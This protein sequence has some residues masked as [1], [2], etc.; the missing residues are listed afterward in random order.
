MK[1]LSATAVLAGV[2]L[3][4][5][6]GDLGSTPSQQSVRLSSIPEAPEAYLAG[7]RL[8]IPADSLTAVVQQYCVNCHNDERLR[9]NL[10]LEDFEVERAVEWA[11]T[12]EKMIVKL[13]AGMMPLPGARRPSPDTLLALVETLESLIDEEAA[14]HPNPGQRTFQRMNRAEYSRAVEDLLD[15]KVD[16]GDYLPLDPKSANFDNIADVQMF[17]PTLMAAYLSAAG[18]ISRLA[19][20][21]PN[22]PVGSRTYTNPGYVSQWDR[23]EGAPRGTRGGIS[24]VHNFWAD[25]EYVFNLAFEHTT[26]G[27]FYGQ[28]GASEQIEVSIDGERVALLDVDKWMH[29]QDPNGVNMETEAVFVRAGPHRVTAA[30]V[31]NFEGVVEDLVSPHDWS[32]ADRQIGVS[33]YGVTALAHL[34]DLVINGPHNPTGVSETPSRRKIFTCRPTTPE[35]ARPCAEEII[36]RLGTQAFRRPA[37]SDELDNLMIFFAEGGEPGGFEAG[38]RTAIQAILASPDFVFRLET[39]PRDVEPGESY[40]IEDRDLASRLSFFLWARPPD[41]ELM[42]LAE[43]GELSDPEVL[44]RQVRRMLGDPRS[45]ALGARFA[46]QWLRLQDL[47]KVHPDRLLFPDFYQQLADDMLLET[48]TFFNSLVRDDRSVFDLFTADFTF[49][50]E[51][52][53]NH[54]GIPGVSG[55]EFRR[56]TYPDARRR[57][58]LGHGSVLTLTSHANR[59]SPVLRGKWVMEVLFGTPPPPPPPGVPDLEETDAVVEGRMLTTRERMEM[60]RTDPTCNSCHRFMDPIGLALDNFDV[61]GRWRIREN[62]MPLDTQGELYDGTPV[63]SPEDLREALMQRPIP[64]V[65]NFTENLMAY[66]LGRRVEYYDKPTIRAITAGAEVDDYRMSSFILGVVNSGAFQ[67]RRAETT[68]EAIP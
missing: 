32:L 6:T 58:V 33:G 52:L 65:R 22:A 47:E 51:R 2:V 25:G 63:T 12:A 40:R 66:A 27:G 43:R 4:G 1:I 37:T 34:K 15:L 44:E 39:R 67:M 62:G 26:T 50:N 7:P 42:S 10:T 68:A 21:D 8:D 64:L 61:T 35:E 45:E 20:G 57:G 23:V 49:V 46:G 3:V 5:R 11:E 14:E 53:A 16:A 29:T 28:T 59:T 54:Y 17:S 55:E 56:V 38:I 18:E 36:T 30:F 60:H 31:R 9:G 24:V 19:V 48:E 13:R 41:D